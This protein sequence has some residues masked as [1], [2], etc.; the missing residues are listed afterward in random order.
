MNEKKHPQHFYSKETIS[1]KSSSRAYLFV[2]MVAVVA[3]VAVVQLG[4]IM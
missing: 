1:M 3:V 2:V 4:V